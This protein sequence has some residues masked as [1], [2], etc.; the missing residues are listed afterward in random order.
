[1]T[2]PQSAV[3]NAS[4]SILRRLHDRLFGAKEAL[5]SFSGVYSNFADA[6]RAAPPAKP[7][8]Y[9]S[10]ESA[11]WYL[12]KLNGVSQEDYPVIYW[13]REA[14]A[15]SHSIFEIGGHVGVAYYGFERILPYPPNLKWTILDVPTIAAAGSDLAKQRGRNNIRFVTAPDQTDGADILLACG[16]L[17]YI[18]QPDLAGTI[19]SLTV[20]PK[21]ILINT[22]PVYDG[23]A[24]ITLQNIGSAY[25]PYRIF[26]RRELIR[27]LTNLGYSLVDFW[28][29]ERAVVIPGHP[30]K[31]F[32]HYSGF[33]FRT[34]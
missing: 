13:L 22:T 10:A 9:D 19:A 8:G 28:Q 24:Y 7:V 1:M 26:N 25:C 18:D 15:D 27:S 29:K 4:P 20:K 33:Y 12:G 2:T 14:F 3:K 6:S 30:E 5:N 21:H 16:A 11:N 17:Q 34:N 32:E 31:S 23:A